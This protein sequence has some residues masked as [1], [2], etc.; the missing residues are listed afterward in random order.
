MGFMQKLADGLAKAREKFLV[1]L[2]ALIVGR[3][4]D[5]SLYE[6]LEE[7]LILNDVGVTASA[8]L[9][10]HLRKLVSERKV[11]EGHF[12]R[13]LLQEIV[14][15]RLGKP[16]AIELQQGRLN[17]F[18]VVGVNG[19][20][21]TT[22]IGKL[23]QYYREQGLKIMCA[24]GDTFR[25]AAAQQLEIWAE[26][27]G[28]QVIAHAAGGDP[29]A[30]VYD[31]LHSARAK[32]IDL[33]LVDTAGRLHNKT[34]LMQELGKVRRIIER[35]APDALREI[36]LVVDA[37]TGQN[38]LSQVREFAEIVPLTGIILTKL[39]GTAKGGIVLA[40]REE[41]QVP[42]KLI[43]VGEKAS[44]LRPFDPQEFA[45]AL[46]SSKTP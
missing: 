9:L 11:Q 2:D 24:A 40:I 31:A 17:V 15:E 25:A 18:L 19:V 16:E 22:S 37:S 33:L 6:E 44:D 41:Q 45:A 36:L 12:L 29:A 39:D 4:I 28:V 8:R 14:S 7:L 34:N 32:G 23:A 30:V 38:A 13:P 26:R 27:A 1:K 21:K 3:K 10:K 20:G 5:E 35:E 43:G 46:L 42:I